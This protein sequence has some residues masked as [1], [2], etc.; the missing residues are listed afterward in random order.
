MADRAWL[1]ERLAAVRAWQQRH[2]RP[3]T[4]NEFGVHARVALREDR[5]RWIREV[6]E[7][8]EETGVGWTMGDYAGGFFFATGDPATGR[9]MDEECLCALGLTS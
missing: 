4:C 6:R 7:L 2:G 8:L 1:A 9:T 5:L 3:V